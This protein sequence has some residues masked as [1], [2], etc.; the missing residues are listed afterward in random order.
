[1]VKRDRPRESNATPEIHLGG[2]GSA[3]GSAGGSGGSGGGDGDQRIGQHS[4]YAMLDEL[5]PYRR[6]TSRSAQDPNTRT[7]QVLGGKIDVSGADQFAEEA[8]GCPEKTLADS[9]IPP[10]SL[11][12]VYAARHAHPNTG[13]PIYPATPCSDDLILP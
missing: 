13:L 1:V 10:N 8:F 12:G 7:R 11:C 3:G 5:D 4:Q 9:L 2:G 6:S